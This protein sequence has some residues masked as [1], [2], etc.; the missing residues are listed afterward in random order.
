MQYKK[1]ELQAQQLVLAFLGYYK[2]VIDGIW[3]TASIQAKQAFECADNYLPAAPT[4]GLP[5]A[6]GSRLPKG[7]LWDKGFLIHKD[8]T[9]ERAKEIYDAQSVPAPKTKVTAAHVIEE[10][11]V[12]KV[13][14]PAET[15]SKNQKP[16][17]KHQEKREHTNPKG[18]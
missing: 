9:V 10:P 18:D 4:F 1:D 13:E 6:P 14:A 8:L 2:G 11:K 12:E 16:Q 17:E 15:Q 3:S 5:F 7:L